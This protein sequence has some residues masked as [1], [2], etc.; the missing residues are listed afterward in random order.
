MGLWATW[1]SQRCPCSL[2]GGW[3]RW[4]LKV[5]SNPKH[6]MTLWFHDSRFLHNSWRDYACPK[7]NHFDHGHKMC[8]QGLMMVLYL[9]AHHVPQKKHDVQLLHAYTAIWCW[10]VTP[11]DSRHGSLW[12]SCHA[13]HNKGPRTPWGHLG[14]TAMQKVLHFNIKCIHSFECNLSCH[15]GKGKMWLTSPFCLI[16]ATALSSIHASGTPLYRVWKSK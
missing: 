8:R 5:L 16:H 11:G 7:L 10:T 13:Q 14:T 4:G 9:H 1:S 12:C 3:T 6:S 2:Q 15:A